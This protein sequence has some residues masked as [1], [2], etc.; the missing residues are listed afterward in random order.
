MSEGA[1]NMESAVLEWQPPILS[2]TTDLSVD[3]VCLVLV[4][5]NLE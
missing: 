2:G 1:L 4:S 3:F 5:E